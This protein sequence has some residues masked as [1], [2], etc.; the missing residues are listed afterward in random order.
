MIDTLYP[1]FQHWS[2]TGS[3]YLFSDP[4]FDDE[5][6]HYMNPDWI[7][8]EEQIKIINSTVCKTDYLILL[9]D[10]GNE[11]RLAQIK[12]KH[13]VLLTGNHDKGNAAYKPYCEEIY[14]G[15][16]FVADR[17]LLSHEPING[18]EN[19]CTNIHGHCH[20]SDYGVFGM[21]GHVNLAADVCGYVPYSLKELIRTHKILAGVENY[22]RIT[23]DRATEFGGI[24]NGLGL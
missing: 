19:F 7:D 23:I 3:V 16:L 12:T 4:H 21:C 1:I 17:I 6:C 10:I 11:K 24:N 20:A 2:K 15:P 14:N 8:P 9:G 18:L 5:D 13:I 22:H